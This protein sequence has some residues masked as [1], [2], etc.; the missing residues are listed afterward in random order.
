M[1]MR[2]IRNTY[3]RPRVSWNT[4]QIQEDRKIMDAYGLRRKRE[5]H[6][7][8]EKLRRYRER[9]RELNASKNKEGEKIL[10]E[11][12]V[13]LGLLE[14]GK[15]IDDVLALGIDD[16]L[17]RRLQSIVFNRGL[18]KT[19]KEARQKIVHGHVVV[20]GR[21]LT[22]PSY[23]VPAEIEHNIKLKPAAKEAS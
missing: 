5:L 23:L 10:L 12:M 6:K 17:K 2:N 1:K 21:R 9:A 4:V 19:V 7:A 16:I 15:A 14:K 11:Q 13:R 3:T 18:A 22:F 20:N 8:R